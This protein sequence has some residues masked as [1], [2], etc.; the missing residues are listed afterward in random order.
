MDIKVR[1]MCSAPTV[2]VRRLLQANVLYKTF[3]NDGV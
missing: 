2:K 1:G 3:L